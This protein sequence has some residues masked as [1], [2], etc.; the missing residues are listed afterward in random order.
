MN[1]TAAIR[2]L[3]ALVPLTPLRKL[4]HYYSALTSWW[5]YDDTTFP[6]I[7]T[8]EINSHC[9]RACIYC[10][11][12]HSPH[13]VKLIDPNVFFKIV[14]RL[15]EIDYRGVVDFIFFSEPTLHPKLADYIRHVKQEV[16]NCITRISTNG[17]LLTSD[18][19]RKLI[20]A[21]LDRIYVMRHNP[22]P[23]GWVERINAL[24]REWRGVFVK[25]DIDQV[26]AE[27]GLNDYGG[28]VKVNRVLSPLR[29]KDGSPHCRVHEHIGQIDIN[30]DW[31]LC[32]T[33]YGKTLKFG[34]LIEDEIMDIWKRSFFVQLRTELRSGKARLPKCQACFCFNA[35][36]V[37]K[38]TQC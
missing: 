30:G 5:Q 9:N 35:P 14:M 6:R 26:E 31:L 25:M 24:D 36:K 10:P 16:P 22:T 2:I 23:A 8:I 7:F 1:K 37:R 17:D 13:P 19:T 38:E 11:N 18:S 27:V 32:C 29:L 15:K 20:G 3:T 28:S 4:Y 12:V 33:D 21:G 34:N